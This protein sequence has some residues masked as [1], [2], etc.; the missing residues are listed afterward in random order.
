[1]KYTFLIF[2]FIW[3]TPMSYAQDINKILWAASWSPDNQYIAVG[4]ADKVLRIYD[5]ISFKFLRNDTLDHWVQRLEWH[6]SRNILAIATT[7]DGSCLIDF[8]KGYKIK[9]DGLEGAG[10][11]AISWNSPGD[12][13]AVADYEGIVH[14][15]NVEGDHLSSFQKENSRSF[16]GIAWHPKSNRLLLIGE[17]IREYNTKGKLMHKFLH[18]PHRV[19]LL[20][21]AWHPSGEFYVLGDYGDPEA[22]MPPVIQFYEEDHTYIGERLGSTS[23][24]R[25]M[26]WSA[27][28][29]K[30]ATAGNSLQI[31]SKSGD[32]LHSGIT[33]N[34]DKLWGVAWSADGSRIVTSSENGH[35]QVWNE[36]AELVKTLL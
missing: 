2:F 3:L 32:L 6:P 5:G 28:G 33:T 34:M 36:K 29:E 8:E 31:W 12:R 15:F 13:I 11:R 4:G 23:E 26:D 30:L 7:G 16:T 10:T 14:L 35:I 1:M 22:Q 25:N 17:Y 21:V 20:S 24:Y 18:R 19:L 27:D 9:L